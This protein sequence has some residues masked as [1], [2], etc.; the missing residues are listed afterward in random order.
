MYLKEI[1]LTGFKSFTE[2]TKLTFEPGITGIVGPNGC[3]KSNIV[4][5]LMWCL[6]EQ[7]SRSLRCQNMGD[8]IFNGSQ[9]RPALG[10]A[11]VSLVFDNTANRIPL[12]FAEIVITRKL[13]RSGESEYF[14]NHVPCRLK[15][16]R[17]LFLDTGIGYEGYS[18]M[19]Q[20]KVEFI[21]T[22]KPEDR[23]ELFEEAAGVAK[24]KA[25]RDEA[26]RKMEKVQFDLLRVDDTISLVRSQ[27][28]QLDLQVRKA[29]QYKSGTEE[30]QKIELSDLLHQHNAI[31]QSLDTC[32]EKLRTA[33]DALMHDTASLD[34][35]EARI[36]DL[37]LK[38]SE[39]EK[40][41]A[42]IQ[43]TV[44]KIESQ[45]TVCE[46]QAR[47]ACLR[48]DELSAHRE[49]IARECELLSKKL[50][51][52]I[53]EFHSH[54]HTIQQLIE[55]HESITSELACK[56]QARAQH[57]AQHAMKQEEHAKLK[58]TLFDIEAH[59]SSLQNSL[60]SL[61]SRFSRIAGEQFSRE[62]EY[63][64]SFE[65]AVHIQTTTEN[66]RD[67]L[68]NAHHEYDLTRTD[69][70]HLNNT[71]TE[72]EEN[73]AALSAIDD[74]I[75]HRQLKICARLSAISEIM[76]SDPYH[77]AATAV[78][79]RPWNGI[80]GPLHRLVS[81]PEHYRGPVT[82]YFGDYLNYFVAETV[83]QAREVITFL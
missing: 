66:V 78:L 30:L 54:C 77:Q 20:G 36:E 49:S 47:A 58:K 28:R 3:G 48:A 1:R 38:L 61:S 23:R 67:R 74:D 71:K 56:E 46:N 6:G 69:L 7:S 62:K 31:T 45:I 41:H 68:N 50:S 37:R 9:K 81:F 44:F 18:I 43:G 75:N 42:E 72:C 13:F 39:K 83:P 63:G 26:L 25:R 65:G 76:A 16:I 11:E 40:H 73:V 52:L 70:S 33:H 79:S 59:R 55:D 14:I 4:D 22:A 29:K 57:A 12:D 64:K 21:L 17:E 19:E 15:D 32:K 10:M 53:D 24:Y 2:K 51:S 82:E 27:I 80:H 8:V 35:D 5:A 60:F 34:R